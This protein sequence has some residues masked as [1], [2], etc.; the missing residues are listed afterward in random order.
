MS[1][2]TGTGD[3]PQRR[4]RKLGILLA[5]GFGGMMLAFCVGDMPFFDSSDRIG[6]PE[7]AAADATA[8]ALARATQAQH[9][10]YGWQLDS[11]ERGQ[12]VTLSLGSNGGAGVSVRKA[13][14]CDRWLVVVATVHPAS[15][16]RDKLVL[17]V[18]DSRDESSSTVMEPGS[19]GMTDT[20]FVADTGAGILRAAGALPLIAA[21]NGMVPPVQARPDPAKERALPSVGYDIL[22][23]RG[24]SLKVAVPM[25]FLSLASLAMVIGVLRRRS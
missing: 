12:P 11:F 22:R 2:V 16:K 9:L 14:G 4:G 7:P 6:P 20:M 24:G 13:P 15:R 3:P 17:Q 1:Q 10:C 8:A 23:G 19:V 21:E 25:M 5:I 18:V